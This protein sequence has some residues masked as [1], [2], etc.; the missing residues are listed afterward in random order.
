MIQRRVNP[1]ARVSD[2]CY[3]GRVDRKE[4]IHFSPRRL[5]I[6]ANPV[7]GL[8]NTTCESGQNRSEFAIAPKSVDEC[9]T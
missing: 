8:L 7:G 2:L 9:S 6:F 1:L 4:R 5:A 3:M